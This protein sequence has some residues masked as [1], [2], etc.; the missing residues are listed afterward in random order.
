MLTHEEESGEV[1]LLT[2]YPILQ[3]LILGGFKKTQY[4]HTKSQLVIMLTLLTRETLTMSKIAEYLSSSN[5][6][7]T[8]VVAPLA[9]EGYIERSVD[10]L[11]RTHVLVRLTPKGRKYIGGCLEV[12]RT[13]IYER[14]SSALSA[15]EMNELDQATQKMKR[16]LEKV[17]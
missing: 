5:E 11:N 14:L 13:N 15:E 3:R 4:V 2:L 6:Q 1:P 10:K 7:A 16:L 8:R 12:L 9:E 17:N